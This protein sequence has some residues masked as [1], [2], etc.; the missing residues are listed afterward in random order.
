MSSLAPH[1]SA[2]RSIAQA[3]SARIRDHIL[4]GTFA[5][6][7][8]LREVQLAALFSASRTPVRHALAANEKDGLLEYTAHRGYIVRP[9]DVADIASAYEVRALIE[10]FA[11]RKAAEQGLRADRQRQ[12]E[13]AIEA[14]AELLRRD[15][16]LDEESREAWRAN[17]SAFHRAIVEQSENRFIGPMLANVQQIPSVYPPVMSSYD[18]QSLRIYND[19]HRAVLAC[20]LHRQGARAE[21]LMREHV[22]LAGETICAAINQDRTA[23]HAG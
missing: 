8:H 21:F 18:P 4:C 22:Y 14:V 15:E 2:P 20:I 13:A 10:G 17:N 6:G 7:E 1:L 3:L 16:P 12:A 5:A 9:F 23:G 11:S 19:Q